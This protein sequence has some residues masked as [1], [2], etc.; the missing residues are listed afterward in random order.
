VQDQPVNPRAARVLIIGY[1]NPLRGDD[2]AGWVAAELLGRELAPAGARAIACHQLTPELAEPVSAASLVLFVDAR[3]DGAAGQ[4]QLR[5]VAPDAA[6][7]SLSH[8][9]SP[10][11]LL[12]LAQQLYGRCPA[13]H[14]ATVAGAEF[15]YAEGLSPAVQGAL[16]ELVARCIALVR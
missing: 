2:G 10:N 6:P 5:P 3:A 15:G 7:P 4:V 16:P 12:A 9:L 11:A 13:A 1:G 14:L 8:E